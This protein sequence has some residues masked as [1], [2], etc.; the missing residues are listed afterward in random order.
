VGFP[1]GQNPQLITQILEFHVFAKRLGW[2]WFQ[3]YEG[4]ELVSDIQ[5]RM[6][7]ALQ[8]QQL[9]GL[10]ILAKVYQVW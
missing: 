8:S 5:T 1:K 10:S 2:S 7:T 9:M 4:C 3:T 6:E